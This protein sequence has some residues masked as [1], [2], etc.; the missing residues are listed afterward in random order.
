MR[1][2]M[3]RNLT[4]G[5][6]ISLVAILCA[7]AFMMASSDDLRVVNAAMKGDKEA[8]RSL[9]KQAADVNAAQGDGTTALHWAALRGDAEMAQMLLY[10]GAN[11]HAKTRIGSYTPLFMA[12]KNGTAPIVDLLLKAGADAN[13]KGTD[14][15]TPLMMA[16]MSGNRESVRLL[17]DKGAELNAKETEHGQTPMIF[18]AAFDRADAI[19]ELAKH[20]ADVN[21]ATEVQ[22]PPQRPNFGQGGGQQQQQQQTPPAAAGAAPASAQP[23]QQAQGGRGGR[24]GRGG[25]AAPPAAPQAQQ[26]GQT[27]APQAQ[28]GQQPP[29][30]QSIVDAAGKSAR[31]G[32]TPLMYAARD[33]RMSAAVALVEN[34]ARLDVRSGDKSTA[35]LVSTIN[36]HFDVAKYLV[37]HGADVNLP[38]ID[39]ATP[40]YGVLHVQWSRESETPQPSIKREHT[41]Y[42]ELMSLLLDRGANPNAKLSRTLWY[43]SYGVAY[44]SA[45]DIGTTPFWKCAAVGDIEGMKLLLARGADPTL[46]NKDGVTPLLIASGAGTHGNDD[47]EAPPGRLSAVKFLVEELHADVNASDNGATARNFDAQQMAQQNQGQQQAGQPQPAV[48]EPQVQAVGRVSSNGGLTALH[49]AASRGDNEMILYLVSKGA[50]VD[51]VTKQGV[52]VVDMANG[53]RQRVQPYASTI[54]LLEM[55]GAKNNHKCV[56]C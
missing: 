27:P 51:A 38:S 44:E 49:N 47:I 21:L 37:E 12:A 16:A 1:G 56:S 10:A 28:Q 24:G 6:T 20:G 5:L 36:G 41:S 22:Q 53:P 15:L 14:G 18:A 48:Q 40:L 19:Q 29:P 52:T 11:V 32:L 3:R 23:Q 31:G 8:V 25:N 7:A 45:S 17:L 39:D 34:G 43:T 26:Q 13:Y 46:T 2:T 54:A 42:L 55:L 33:G 50:N 35:L 9:V 4:I 30:V